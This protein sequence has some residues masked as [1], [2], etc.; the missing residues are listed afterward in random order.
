MARRHS[1]K[2]I[3]FALTLVAGAAALSAACGQDGGVRG[4]G[5]LRARRGRD[6]PRERRHR[7][8]R[9]TSASGRSS[10]ASS[11]PSARRPS[12]PRS[13]A[14]VL[15]VV[16]EEGQAVRAGTLLAR[17]EGRTLQDA[18]AS[19][20]SSSDSTEQT[21]A[22]GREGGDA[23]REPGQG[24]ALGRARSRGRAQRGVQTKAAADDAQRA[25]RVGAQ[26]AR[27]PDGALADSGHRLAAST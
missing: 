12:A 20:Q 13:G 10:R 16:P 7:S 2:H 27:R 17:I 6:R 1:S 18:L 21:G 5:R 23:H 11:G 26:G 15:Q 24:R 8:R 9:V 22:V 3:S 4:P 25:G 19:A 14:R